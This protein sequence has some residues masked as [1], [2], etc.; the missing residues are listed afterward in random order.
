MPFRNKIGTK[1]LL[2][3]S[4]LVF[5]IIDKIRELQKGTL[6]AENGEYGKSFIN[7]IILDSLMLTPCISIPQSLKLKAKYWQKCYIQSL[8]VTSFL[9]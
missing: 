7:A 8:N 6:L 9:F 4:V 1:F 3:K 5:V 2:F